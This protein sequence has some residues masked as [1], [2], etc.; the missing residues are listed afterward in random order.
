EVF[1]SCAKHDSALALILDD[2]AVVISLAL[3]Y[4]IPPAS[5]AKSMGR[6]PAGPLDPGALD[7]PDSQGSRL[8]ASVVGAVLDLLCEAGPIGG[9]IMPRPIRGPNMSLDAVTVIVVWV[10]LL[11]AFGVL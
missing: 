6:L 11:M 3:Q 2:L 8:P 5:L 4:G 10:L 7:Q 1:L 9:P